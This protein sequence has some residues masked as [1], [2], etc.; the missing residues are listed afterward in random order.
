MREQ[1]SGQSHKLVE[2]SLTSFSALPISPTPALQRGL[3]NTPVVAPSAVKPVSGDDPQCTPLPP[4]PAPTPALLSGPAYLSAAQQKALP[5][6]P[7]SA[8]LD[9]VNIV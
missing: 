4:S 2:P 7:F 3:P 5:G 9:R 8:M 6:T 1:A